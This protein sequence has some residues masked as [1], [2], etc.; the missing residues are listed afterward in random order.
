MQGKL[1]ETRPKL[2]DTIRHG[3]L[4][5]STDCVFSL[6]T[7]LEALRIATSLMIQLLGLLLRYAME[8]GDDIQ[9]LTR[10]R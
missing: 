4:R 2:N 1:E 5:L 10:S 6:Q 7:S 3:L 9:F 8:N